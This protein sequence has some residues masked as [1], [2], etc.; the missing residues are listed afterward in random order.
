MG[1]NWPY[2]VNWISSEKEENEN[3]LLLLAQRMRDYYASHQTYYN[4][5]ITHDWLWQHDAYLP[6]AA[7]RGLIGK[8]NQILEIGCGNAA[9]LAVESSW[10]AKYTG[11]DFSADLLKANK[12]RY[13]NANFKPISN[14][15]RYD[16][17]DESFD[18]VFSQ[19]VIEHTVFPKTFLKETIRLLKPGGSFVIVAPN[20]RK[21]KFLPSQQVNENGL[22]SRENLKRFRLGDALSTLLYNRLV[23]PSALR[24]FDKR[25]EG[26]VVNLEPFAFECNGN[27]RPDNDAVYVTCFDEIESFCMQNG[28]QTVPNTSDLVRFL[29]SH[30]LGYLNMVKVR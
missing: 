4:T 15:S 24:T 20:F 28:C 23:I 5:Y 10:Q 18:L 17:P 3:E 8:A 14:F 1:I 12:E 21:H 16:F 2:R 13:P 25:Q 27:F 7:L 6:L 26:F 11:I 9:C 29:H 19:F 22:T 30:R